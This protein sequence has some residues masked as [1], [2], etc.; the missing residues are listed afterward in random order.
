VLG[1]GGAG[2]RGAGQGQ[3]D[4]NEGEWHLRAGDGGDFVIAKFLFCRT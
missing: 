1:R 3:I 2:V 4:W